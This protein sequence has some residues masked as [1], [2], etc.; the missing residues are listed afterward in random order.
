[1]YA[2]FNYCLPTSGAG[3]VISQTRGS[4]SS[5]APTTPKEISGPHL[6]RCGR[7]TLVAHVW[8]AQNHPGSRKLEHDGR[9]NEGR[10][11]EL[12]SRVL[13]G[14]LLAISETLQGL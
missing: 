4:T 10:G 7:I 6:A 13:G 1:M 5:S 12:H 9:K 3:S 2:G 11:A 14:R 8:A